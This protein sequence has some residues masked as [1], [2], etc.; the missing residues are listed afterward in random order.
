MGLFL[1]SEKWNKT[2]PKWNKTEPKWN[3]EGAK[4]SPL[5]HP[6]KALILCT[7][8]HLFHFFRL[9]FHMEKSKKPI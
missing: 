7:L 8:F 4:G 6:F 3:K 2:R 1:C 5:F 9:L